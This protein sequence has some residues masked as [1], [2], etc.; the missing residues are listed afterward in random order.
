MGEPFRRSKLKL[1]AFSDLLKGKITC[2]NHFSLYYITTSAHEVV[3]AENGV[4]GGQNAPENFKE[5]C[6]RSWSMYLET[7]KVEE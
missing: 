4:T 6:K 2:N 1:R 5:A 3:L 7:T